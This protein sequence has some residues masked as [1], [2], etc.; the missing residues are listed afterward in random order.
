MVCEVDGMQDDLHAGVP[1]PG[2]QMKTLQID[3]GLLHK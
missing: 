3:Q 2:A 1:L